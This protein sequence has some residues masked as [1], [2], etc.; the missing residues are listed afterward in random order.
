M[1]AL[2]GV[3]HALGS[4]KAVRGAAYAWYVEQRWEHAK[5]SVEE[6]VTSEEMEEIFAQTGQTDEIRKKLSLRLNDYVRTIPESFMLQLEEQARLHLFLGRL[7]EFPFASFFR[8]FNHMLSEPGDPE[9]SRLRARAGHA[10]PG[11]HGEAAR[12]LQPHPSMRPRLP[13]RGGTRSRTTSS[14]ARG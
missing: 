8:Y 6:F 10:Y 9:V 5:R 4:D 3:Y 2:A 1:Q 13:V 11:P 14:S 7:V 12:G